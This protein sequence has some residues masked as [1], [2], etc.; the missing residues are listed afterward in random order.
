[1]QTSAAS[2]L[3]EPLEWSDYCDGAILPR[4]GLLEPIAGPERPIRWE[5]NGTLIGGRPVSLVV[6]RFNT[7]ALPISP[8][9]DF[10]DLFGTIVA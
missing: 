4:S 6:I 3:G 5:S 7:R 8:G 9:C 10:I 1:M 2:G